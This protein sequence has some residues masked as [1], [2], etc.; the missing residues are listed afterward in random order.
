MPLAEWACG[1]LP[2]KSYSPPQSLRPDLQGTQANKP[3]LALPTHTGKEKGPPPISWLK[4]PLIKFKTACHSS[5]LS[6]YGKEVASRYINS[7]VSRLEQ[8]KYSVIFLIILVDIDTTLSTALT[9]L[10]CP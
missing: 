8:Q 6:K 3:S 1:S 7:Y 5:S 10:V 4:R 9:A 2:G